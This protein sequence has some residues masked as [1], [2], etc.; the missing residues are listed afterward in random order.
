[1]NQSVFKDTLIASMNRA[2]QHQ[3]VLGRLVNE[4]PDLQT[5]ADYVSVEVFDTPVVA[6]AAINLVITKREH[7]RNLFKSFPPVDMVRSDFITPHA[8]PAYSIT[9]VERVMH[10]YVPTNRVAMNLYFNGHLLGDHERHLTSVV[11]YA[12]LGELS[13]AY[14]TRLLCSCVILNDTARLFHDHEMNLPAN[15]TPILD[16][17]TED[18]KQRTAYIYWPE[19][20][21]DTW[22]NDFIADSPGEDDTEWA[23]FIG[24]KL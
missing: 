3:R 18:D 2:A 11:W 13:P 6:E 21:L 9:S 12:R 10:Q 22:L 4:L 5:E 15:G 17:V 19:T 16:P 20:D 1:M 14:H 23:D 24:D 8:R 7:L